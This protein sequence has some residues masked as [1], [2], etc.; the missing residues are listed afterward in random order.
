MADYDLRD[1]D[2]QWDDNSKQPDPRLRS[3][4]SLLE[5]YLSREWTASLRHANNDWNS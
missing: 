3:N 4:P 1:Q 5:Y 2:G